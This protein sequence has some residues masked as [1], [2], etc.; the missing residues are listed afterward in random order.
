MM[1]QI[2]T[3][4]KNYLNFIKTVSILIPVAVAIL[5][6][7]PGKLE[8]G[9][10]VRNLPYINAL[11]NSLTSIFLISALIAVKKQKISLHKNLMMSSLIL[12]TLFLLSYV[13]YHASVPSVIFGDA[14]FNGVLSADELELIGNTRT[15]YLF[16]LFSHI[17]LSIVVI[18]FVLFSFY[19]SLTAQVGKH[20][21]VVKFSFP[22]WLYVSVTGVIVYLMIS[23]YYV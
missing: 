3:S 7:L 18:P 21:K 6:Y 20:K 22:I 15:I 16:V 5:I 13:T 19:Y 8:V 12:G 4:N 9:E 11:I 17:G 1:E 10:W 2:L 23:P 14:N